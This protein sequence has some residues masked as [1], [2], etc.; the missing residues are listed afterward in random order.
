MIGVLKGGVLAKASVPV[1]RAG[2][3]VSNIICSI[4]RARRGSVS[5]NAAT[6]FLNEAAV[7]GRANGRGKEKKSFFFCC[8]LVFS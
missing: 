4:P 8:S 2:G 1:G 5:S 3:G 7:S 6:V